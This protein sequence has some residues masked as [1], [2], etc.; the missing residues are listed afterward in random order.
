ML[1]FK[2]KLYTFFWQKLHEEW[3]IVFILSASIYF[4]GGLVYTVFSEAAVENWALD[5]NEEIK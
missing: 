4:V 5:H 1:A 2:L 3:Q